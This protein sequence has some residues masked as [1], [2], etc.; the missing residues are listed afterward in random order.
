[1]NPNEKTVT[2]VGEMP[3][4]MYELA[5]KTF[6][7]FKKGKENDH[8][9][10]LEEF[11]GA[12]V[13]DR[14]KWYHEE[15][16]DEKKLAHNGNDLSAIKCAKRLNCVDDGKK[17]KVPVIVYLPH[18][19]ISDI[20]EITEFIIMSGEEADL[21]TV[22]EAFIHIAFEYGGTDAVKSPKWMK[23]KGKVGNRR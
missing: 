15:I 4:D 10:S 6:D 5:L 21:G 12:A 16:E 8:I 22:I 1:M 2:F 23:K 17:C 7:W 19:L 9:Q 14:L 20:E 13:V 11:F 3:V 18:C